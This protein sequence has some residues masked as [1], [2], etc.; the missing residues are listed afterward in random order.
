MY[1]WAYVMV[2]FVFNDLIFILLI[3]VEYFYHNFLNFFFITSWS[4]YQQNEY[5]VIKYK[6]DHDI[7]SWKFRSWLGRH[8]IVVGCLEE[9]FSFFIVNELEL[10][11]FVCILLY[12]YF[13]LNSKH[14]TSWNINHLYIHF[15]HQV[16]FCI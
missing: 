15:I 12:F 6:K 9:N 14:V 7:C 2:F 13:S 3:S 5:Q 10:W 16:L 8:K 11:F 1:P 4:R